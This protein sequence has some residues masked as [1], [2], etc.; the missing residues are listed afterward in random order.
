MSNTTQPPLPPGSPPV[1]FKAC[2]RPPVPP[3]PPFLP[4]STSGACPSGA[5]PKGMQDRKAIDHLVAQNLI[6]GIKEAVSI[7]PTT[8]SQLTPAAG[9]G[10]DLCQKTKDKYKTLCHL[11]S[12]AFSRY[13]NEDDPDTSVICGEHGPGFF[14]GLRTSSDWAGPLY[15]LECSLPPYDYAHNISGN[16]VQLM[17]Q[18]F[19]GHSEFLRVGVLV[20]VGEYVPSYAQDNVPGY[21][22]RAV[23]LYCQTCRKCAVGDHHNHDSHLRGRSVAQRNSH[24]APPY[25]AEV[26]DLVLKQLDQFDECV[27][28][29]FSGH[30]D[31]EE[32]K[33][34][35]SNFKHAKDKAQM[36]YHE[37]LLHPNTGDG[38]VVGRGD[39]PQ[40]AWALLWPLTGRARGDS[41]TLVPYSRQF[42][43]SS[44][45]GRGSTWF[46]QPMFE[47][48]S[49][50]GCILLLSTLE[51]MRKLSP[52]GLRGL[53][54][55][56]VLP[57]NFQMSWYDKCFGWVNSPAT[58]VLSKFGRITRDGQPALPQI[59]LETEPR[60]LDIKQKIDE[61]EDRILDNQAKGI[62]PSREG[63]EPHR[64]DSRGDNRIAARSTGRYGRHERSAHSRDRRGEG[65]HRREEEQRKE[66]T[67][68]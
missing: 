32:V 26:A 36:L 68:R 47:R 7:A 27:K 54:H 16:S 46:P 48:V 2:P 40:C 56:D 1:E 20:A 43:S 64:L 37:K 63:M 9:G 6:G 52:R 3:V 67:L 18:N 12:A 5:F 58:R 31:G 23:Q 49:F 42:L 38:T 8:A 62:L 28:A 51:D 14:S 25:L 61:D 34:R 65:R 30:G 22:C 13:G 57:D 21:E 39:H 17:R 55:P 33:K 19:L 35:M 24:F 29:H 66:S 53:R 41:S 15:A 44:M 10:L 4:D 45:Y 50:S 59:V 11:P 60:F